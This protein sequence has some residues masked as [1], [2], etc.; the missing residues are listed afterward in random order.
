MNHGSEK[1]CHV[2]DTFHALFFIIYK[3]K[4][5]AALTA[6]YLFFSK[7]DQLLW[8]GLPPV[9]GY[10]R[11]PGFETLCPV[12]R[13][14][15][16]RDANCPRFPARPSTHHEFASMIQIQ[17]RN[18]SKK[19]CI[20]STC[21]WSDFII[22]VPICLY[23]LNCT[24]FAQFIHRKII[25]IVSTRCPILRLKCTKYD[26]DSGSAPDH[27][28]GAYSTPPDPLAGFKGPYF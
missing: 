17:C 13:V 20:F 24:K 7:H 28:E 22:L 1:W 19:Y 14:N 25:K 3:A 27:T 9:L 11:H 21:T 10:P 2:A 26:F 23:C 15:P 8:I 16:T 4:V 6:T 12:S 18:F 5:L